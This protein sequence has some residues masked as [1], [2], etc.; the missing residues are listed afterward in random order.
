M[1]GDMFRSTLSILR[2]YFVLKENLIAVFGFSKARQPAAVRKNWPSRRTN[3]HRDRSR[4]LLLL[5]LR[6]IFL[7]PFKFKGIRS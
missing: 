6:E 1:N 2:C 3:A 7:I 4:V 5:L